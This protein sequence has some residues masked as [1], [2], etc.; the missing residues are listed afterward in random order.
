DEAKRLA[1]EFFGPV[2]ARQD[3]V[4]DSY[5]PELLRSFE[6]LLGA[7]RASMDEQLEQSD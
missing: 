1:D 5:P 3:A 2:N 4:L 6:E 7:L